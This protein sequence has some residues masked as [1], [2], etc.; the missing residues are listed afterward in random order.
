MMHQNFQS[1]G[2]PWEVATSSSDC[3]FS[4]ALESRKS[5]GEREVGGSMA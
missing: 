1:F 5:D 3:V 4:A 2:T